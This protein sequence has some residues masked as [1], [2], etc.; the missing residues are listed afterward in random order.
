M[1]ADDFSRVIDPLLITSFDIEIDRE[2]GLIYRARDIFGRRQSSGQP[3]FRHD[4]SVSRELL[5]GLRVDRRNR[6][7][8]LFAVARNQ[9]PLWNFE[10]DLRSGEIGHIVVEGKPASG[11]EEI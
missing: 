3:R 5:F 11:V 4:E 6:R 7:D 8:G 9:N 10:V 1:L 2:P